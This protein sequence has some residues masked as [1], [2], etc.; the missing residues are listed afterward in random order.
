MNIKENN[1][2]IIIAITG[3][4]GSV[5]GIN[6][7]K[8]L[9]KLNIKTI[10]VLSKDAITTLKYELNLGYKEIISLADEYYSNDDI[11]ASIASG[12]VITRGMVIA[13]CSVKTLSA[14]ANCYS[15]NLISRASDVCLKERRRLVILFR[16]S[17][18][19]LGHIKLMEQ[20]A[21][22]GAIIVPPMPSF[23]NNPKSIEDVVNSS[24]S[25]VLDLFNIEN[26]VS[27]RW[28]K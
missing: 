24:V 4:S 22:S 14:V 9:R 2:P 11:A 21:L 3:A 18:V 8:I 20:A 27:P 5:Y 28:E 15:N 17:P 26:N 6:L 19:H 10:L 13:P 7:L 23:Y 1:L 16:E 25:K 12:S